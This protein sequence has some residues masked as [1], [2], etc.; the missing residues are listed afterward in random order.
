MVKHQR[1][2]HQRGI[3]SSDLDDGE[4][5]ESDSG[6]STSTSHPAGQLQWSHTINLAPAAT[7]HTIHRAHSFADFGQHVDTVEVQNVYGHRHSLS[8][9]SHQF[10]ASVQGYPQAVPMMHRSASHQ[11]HSSFYVP[12]Q[13]N[14]G[15]ATMNL[16]PHP[17]QTQSIS[18]HIERQ[19]LTQNSPSS[20]SSISGGSPVSHDHFYTQQSAQTASYTSSPV[21]QQNIVHYPQPVQQQLAQQPLPEPQPQVQTVQEEYHHPK[22]EAYQSPQDHWYGHIAYQPPVVGIMPHGIAAYLPTSS[23]LDPWGQKLD[24]FNDATLQMPSTRI[25]SL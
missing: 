9:G 5:S 23:F 22:I 4:T 20:Y 2:S 24:D 16:T 3:H 7:H 1:R 11:G 18:Q 12:E 10:N 13:N 8:N 25:E 21:E 14:P 19:D 15:V 17:I 6:E